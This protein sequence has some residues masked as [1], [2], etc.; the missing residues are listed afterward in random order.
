MFEIEVIIFFSFS[1]QL[2][3]LTHFLTYFNLFNGMEF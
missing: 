2:I 3:Q 1:R